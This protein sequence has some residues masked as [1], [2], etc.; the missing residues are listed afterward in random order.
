MSLGI[1]AAPRQKLPD[2]A[3]GG[4]IECRFSP[5]NDNGGSTVAIAG[6]NYAIVASD[7]RLTDGGYG[8]LSRNLPKLYNLT[9]NIVLGATGCHADV[10]TLTRL[11][12]ARIKMFK[13]THNATIQTKETSQMLA[14]ML[15][16]KR[17]F[18]YSVTNI[19]AGLDEHGKGRIYGYDPVGCVEELNQCSGGAGVT[20]MQSLLDNQ[21]DKR[22]MENA[23]KKPLSL[24]EAER[25]TYDCFVS[26]AERQIHVG[27]GVCMRIIT[28]DG[29]EE[30]FMALRKD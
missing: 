13:Y 30:K 2:Y 28:K 20:L 17:F 19:L 1:T 12:G 27:D 6:D 24:E 25:L 23:D 7:T 10:L 26:A 22:N 9:D 16:A 21:V 3:A 4:P 18:P 14:N 15:Y 11:I 5:Y 29:I 8:I